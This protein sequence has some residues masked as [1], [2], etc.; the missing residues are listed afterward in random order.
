MPEKDRVLGTAEGFL[1]VIPV[2]LPVGTE[3]WRCLLLSEESISW[4]T[5]CQSYFWNW[6]EPHPQLEDE[7]LLGSFRFKALRFQTLPLH[8]NLSP[9][10][11][12]V[13]F[14]VVVLPFLQGEREVPVISGAQTL[15]LVFK[16]S[17]DNCLYRDLHTGCKRGLQTLLKTLEF[18][19]EAYPH[20]FICI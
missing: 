11:H 20:L 15:P 19:W 2:F 1:V 6:P 9:T 16:C 14:R 3:I 13:C 12:C 4:Q 5:F 7:L 17:R 18:S 10:R 8:C